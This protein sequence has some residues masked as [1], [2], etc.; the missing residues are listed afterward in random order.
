VLADMEPGLRA[1]LH[2]RAAEL[3][4]A[5][6]LPATAIAEHLR[7]ARRATTPWA[8][9]TL[10]EAAR[11]ALADGHV[12][13]AIDYLRLACDACADESARAKLKTTLVRAQ[14]RMNPAASMPRL[15]EL[16]DTMR[17]GH[18]DGSD[19]VVLVKALLWHGRT[20]DA[21]TVLTLLADS[22]SLSDPETVSE[23][24]TTRPWLRF[25]FA[26]LLDFV[27][28]AAAG[29]SEPI[30]V[31]TAEGRRR[32]DA[33]TVLDTVLTKGPSE[34]VVEEAERI[35]RNTRLEGMGMDTVE[36][37]LLALTYAESPQRAA[38]WCDRLMTEAVAREA[39]G[40]LARL[41]A[42]RSEI[43]VRSGDLLGAE[44][45]ARTS[46]EVIPAAGWG[47]A[48]GGCLGSL[49][50]ALTAMGRHDEAAQAL[51][52]PVPD[53]MLQ[54]RFGLPYLRARGRHSLAGED[55]DG[56]LSDFMYCGELMDRWSL[57]SSG[58][59]A[60]RNDAAEAWLLMGEKDRARPLLEE[61]LARADRRVSP[62]THGYALRLLAECYE[63]RQRP[64]LLRH[65]A[66]ALQESGDRY[67]LALALGDLTAAFVE[68]GETRRAR[69]IG[70]QAWTVASEC[71]AEPLCRSL[72]AHS[73]EAGGEL[74]A[75]V[76]VLSEAEQRVADLVALGL[77]NREI[78]QRLYITVST[79]EQHLTRAY[80]KLGV[81]G[82]AD[83]AVALSA[84]VSGFPVGIG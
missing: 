16:I 46:L 6:G 47:V 82:R 13:A 2:H 24:R 1:D 84:G 76:A 48:L 19:A 33:A 17:A 25:S 10:A 20:E 14:W 65:A 58:L 67:G 37:A 42:I 9:A 23:L 63:L 69:V 3:G 83:L 32:F 74:F 60:W 40:R 7:A 44:G 62:Q 31:G 5:D 81:T 49:L 66:D 4:H 28:P 78:S 50:T 30:P 70:R 73:G 35:L 15:A 71:H 53:A 8:V 27:P 55:P 80:R 57:D 59:I 52:L 34:Q 79:V 75:G 21:A 61:Q 77:T 51:N 72:A 38:P 22:Q 64:S 12:T 43:C 41:A 68:L 56:A 29:P 39:P 36:A 18:L 11:S 54:S 26:P 45:H